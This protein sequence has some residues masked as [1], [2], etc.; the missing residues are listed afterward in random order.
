L[1]PRTTL[2][3]VDRF[4]RYQN[5]SRFNEQADPGEA[6]AAGTEQTEF[7]TN[8]VTATLEHSLDARNLLLLNLSYDLRDYSDEGQVDS[9]YGGSLVYQNRWS[10]RATLGGSASWSSQTA[11]LQDLDLDDRDTDYFNVSALFF[12]TLSPTLRFEVSAGPA[13]V[14]SDVA[15]FDPPATVNRATFPLRKTNGGVHFVD[16]DTC[17]RNGA[18]IR[19]LTFECGLLSPALGGTDREPGANSTR[20]PSRGHSSPDDSQPTSRNVSLVGL[21]AL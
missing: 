8:D 16:A 3:L 14:V 10:E 6:V 5:A 15:D 20:S 4:Q 19:L 9:T 7:T 12:Y 18:G 11:H 21:G 1:G 2:G 13:L 17:P